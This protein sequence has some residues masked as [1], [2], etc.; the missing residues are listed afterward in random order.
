M[1]KKAKHLTRTIS[2]NGVEVIAEI[3]R[4]VAGDSPNH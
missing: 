4:V 3:L 1:L 2:I